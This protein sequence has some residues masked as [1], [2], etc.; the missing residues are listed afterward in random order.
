MYKLLCVGQIY[1]HQ[2]ISFSFDPSEVCASVSD[3]TDKEIE[4]EEY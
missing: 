4:I 2:L 1:V 3:L